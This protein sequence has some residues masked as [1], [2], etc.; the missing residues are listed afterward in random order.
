VIH[1]PIVCRRFIGRHEELA[2]LHERRREAGSSHG[3]IVLVGGEA[4]VG[5]SRLLAE[6][7]ALLGKSRWRIAQAACLEFAQRP[8]GPVLGLLARFDPAAAELAPAASKLEQLDAIAEALAAAASRHATIAIIEDLHWADVATMELL[9]HLSASLHRMRMLVV[10]SFRPEEFEPAHPAYAGV[11]KLARMPR[12]GRIDLAPLDAQEQ[13]TFI[14][15]TLGD[16]PLSGETRRTVASVSDGNPFF[17]EELLKDAVERRGAAVPARDAATLPATVHAAVAGRLRPLTERERLVVGQAAVIGRSFDLRL[18]AE[19]LEGT[20]ESILPAL[21]RARDLQ[22]IEEEAANA[23]RFRHALTR[24]AIYGDF[25]TAQLQPLHRTIALALERRADDPPDLDSLAYHWWA[26]GDRPRAAAYNERAG[27]AAAAVHAH[28]DAIVLYERAAHA[29]QAEPAVRARITEKIAD[30]RVALA[31]YDAA[32]TAFSAA[33]DLFRQSGDAEAEAACRV[34]VALQRYT[35]GQAEPTAELDAMLVRLDGDQILARSRIHL[36]IAWLAATFYQPSVA[37]RH[38]ALVEQRAFASAPDIAVRFFNVRAWVSM[39]VGDAERFRTD[40][41][42]WLEAARRA[43][44]VGMV[45]AAHYNGAFGYALFGLHQDAARN[46]RAALEIAD[47]Q[48]S[49]HVA[50]SARGM[51]AFCSLLSGDLQAARDALD[52]LRT[53]PTGNEVVRAYAMAFGTLV[54]S[55]LDD[56]AL[57]QHWF[58]RLGGSVSPFFAAICGAGFAEVLVRRGRGA[59]ACALL[60]DGI[61]SGERQ[62]GNVLTLLAVARYGAAEDLPAARAVL[63]LAADAPSELVERHALP[64]FDALVC[65]RRGVPVDRHAVA[66]AADGLRR[67]GFPLLEASARELAGERDA[68]LAIFRRCGAVHD[69]RRL[70]SNAPASAAAAPPP[71]SAQAA[72]LSAREREIAALVALG[73]SN[74][75]IGRELSISHK[76]VEKHLSSMFNKLGFSSRAQ[77]AAH[78]SSRA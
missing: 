9:A 7:C 69:V 59:E 34:R 2:Y 75:E 1:R 35:L 30:R 46:I 60:H 43:D 56:D 3:G 65:R 38:L 4:G 28:D 32:A 58:D 24:E 12:A 39:L 10:A 67:I 37:S 74:V 62:R 76:T 23:F 66:A 27:D 72:A 63:E 6:F 29:T 33:A 77:L 53:L 13:E 48:R 49:R 40:H 54:G 21:R 42:A 52:A 41:D 17:L 15:E 51:S 44:G 55:Y 8:Y 5:K 14:D 11:A 70:E 64:L 31:Q 20:I 45:A 26:S 61:G 71:V 57:I 47:A 18:L 19:T 68:A 22:L 78:V 25:L 16:I 50:A 36:G 73:R